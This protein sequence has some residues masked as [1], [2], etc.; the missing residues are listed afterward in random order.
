MVGSATV[1]SCEAGNSKDSASSA[2]LTSRWVA[3]SLPASSEEGRNHIV[4]DQPTIA[5]VAYAECPVRLVHAEDR[6]RSAKVECSMA[7]AKERLRE[8]HYLI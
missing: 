3:A 8:N 4:D 2:T 6:H 1:S 7:L 5:N